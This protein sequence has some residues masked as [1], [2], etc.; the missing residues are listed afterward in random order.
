[1][2]RCLVTDINAV[3]DSVNVGGYRF[4]C[5]LVE[6]DNN[7]F[8]IIIAQSAAQGLADAVAT[9]S[10]YCNLEIRDHPISHLFAAGLRSEAQAETV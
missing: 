4:G 3:G 6:V 5:R 7:D 1:M 2:H 9:T 8:H 10:H